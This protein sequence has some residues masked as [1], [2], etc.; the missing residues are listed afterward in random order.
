VRTYHAKQRQGSSKDCRNNLDSTRTR[1]GWS[2]D[3]GLNGKP[4]VNSLFGQ[5]LASF[6]GIY[7]HLFCAGFQIV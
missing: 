7:Q 4:L 2:G 6:I 5:R 3:M 1:C